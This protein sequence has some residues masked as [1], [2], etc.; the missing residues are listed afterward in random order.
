ML[1]RGGAGV[2]KVELE[3]QS[4]SDGC[5][6]DGYLGQI[7][8]VMESLRGKE[9]VVVAHSGAGGLVT[10]L[11]PTDFHT[12]IFLDA[13]FCIEPAARFDLFGDRSL[14]EAWRQVATTNSGYLT[15]DFLRV[16]GEQIENPIQ[17]ERF[18]STLRSVPV[19]VYEEQI[20]PHSDWRTDNPGLYIRW[21]DSYIDDAAR[22][23]KA[24]LSVQVQL[25]SHFEMINYP[26]IV[27]GL[28]T[29]FVA[30]LSRG[31]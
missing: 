21:T 27:S 7:S 14:V 25:G 26:A 3:H 28:I 6:H 9:V 5:F 22:A 2:S 16:F 12:A 31:R 19:A 24:G 8:D 29:D 17:R 15:P 20:E 23:E 11:P 4:T 13:A 30:Q 18:V 10:S 1:A